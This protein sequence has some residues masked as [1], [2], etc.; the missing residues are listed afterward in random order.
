[1]RVF[2]SWSGDRSRLVAEALKEW[3]PAVIQTLEPWVS[4]VDIAKGTRSLEEIHLQLRDS[5][6]GIICLTPENLKAEWIHFEAG[7][8]A[9]ALTEKKDASR[10]YRTPTAWRDRMAR[11]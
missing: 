7:A 8:I 11:R 6:F 10:S 4:S 3:L 2:I 5:E 1:M 9:K